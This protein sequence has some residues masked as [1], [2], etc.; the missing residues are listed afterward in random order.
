MSSPATAAATFA[1]R[2]HALC[3]RR[4]DTTCQALFSG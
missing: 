2:R 4:P 3:I 1:A